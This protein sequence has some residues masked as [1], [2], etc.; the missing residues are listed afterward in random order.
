MSKVSIFA[1]AAVIAAST[2]LSNAA[3]SKRIPTLSLGKC[4]I[5]IL[6][7][8]GIKPLAGATLALNQAADGKAA[9]TA[10][11]NKAGKCEI[12][13]AEGSYVLCVNE[14]P[15]TLINASKEGTMDWARIVVSETPMLIGGQAGEAGEAVVVGSEAPGGFA[16]FVQ[17]NALLVA[18]GAVVFLG[19]SYYVVDKADW[20]SSGG[21]G[22]I[23]TEQQPPA[24]TRNDDDDGDAP[25]NS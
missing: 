9:V 24:S 12:S 1:I 2:S 14:K 7:S 15:V 4:S 16:T 5:T 6:D 3:E 20:T 10:V 19:G 23:V 8:N 11:A 21:A 22:V 25:S 13:V 17:A 18:G